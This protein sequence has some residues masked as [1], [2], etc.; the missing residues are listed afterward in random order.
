MQPVALRFAPAPGGQDPLQRLLHP[1]LVGHQWIAQGRLAD[2]A[3]DR[4][5]HLLVGGFPPGR[6][7]GGFA[8]AALIQRQAQ[9]AQ[10]LAA[11]LPGSGEHQREGGQV[12]AG[13]AHEGTEALQ[14]ILRALRVAI[15]PFDAAQLILVIGKE[16]RLGAHLP[17]RIQQLAQALDPAQPG[18]CLRLRQL[19]QALNEGLGFLAAQ[20]AK[21][22]L[23]VV[24]QV[25]LLAPQFGDQLLA[26]QL[27][28]FA[29]G[30]LDLLQQLRE[31][32]L[33][34]HHHRLHGGEALQGVIQAHRIEDAEAVFADRVAQARGAADHLVVKDAAVHAAQKH[35]V[36]DLGHIH[37]GGEQIHGDCHIGK[38]LIL[39]APDQLRGLVA[40][41]RDLRY[42]F[43]RHAAVT[44]VKCFLEQNHN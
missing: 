36:A 8:V 25:P 19:L 40:A 2:P 28:V 29:F 22:G 31:G 30:A 17:L 27:P 35:N 18:S 32:D 12:V 24:A 38:R 41:A 20:Q 37:A 11:Q 21:A 4:G 42:R 7:Q 33:R 9:L 13:I 39:E 23:G 44:H 15:A 5:G 16:A 6:G 10:I 1:L 43:I 14:V 3:H 26:H 34:V